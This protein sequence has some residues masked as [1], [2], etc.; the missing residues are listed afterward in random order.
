MIKLSP[1]D[2]AFLWEQ[3][4]RCFYL[5]VVQGIRQP[6]MP[7][8]A[9]FKRLES[10]QMKF[11]DGRR[12]TE[13]LPELPAG[14]IR[15][16][17]RVVE[18][19]PGQVDGQPEW[20]IYGKIDSLIEFDDGSWGILDFKTTTVNPEKAQLYGRQL[21]SYAHAFE[22]PASAPRILKGK[23]PGLGPISKLG[24]LCFEPGE[25][26][27][28][29]PGRQAYKGQVQWIEIPRNPEKFLSFVGETLKVLKGEMPPPTPT[30][31]WCTYAATMKE[32]KPGPPPKDGVVSGPKCPRCES[33]M[34]QRN[35]KFG[36]FW[37][38]TR[39]PE[40]KGTRKTGE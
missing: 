8:A 40:C 27:L 31:E 7:M 21:H 28:E 22:H 2:F 12:T 36:A 30:C 33:P 39:Y 18:S 9:I 26:Q 14:I 35:G 32:M 3:C 17:E 13:L 4:K 16:G 23:A 24:I 34:T 6:S 20:F 19:E 29:S 15:C 11:Y 25:L 37:G 38:C 5:K 1:S 10:L